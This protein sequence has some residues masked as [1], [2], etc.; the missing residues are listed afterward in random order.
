MKRAVD[1]KRR[2]NPMAKDMD[3]VAMGSIISNERLPSA[4]EYR[5][6]FTFL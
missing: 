1:F 3:E 4:H 2:N 5:K 6:L